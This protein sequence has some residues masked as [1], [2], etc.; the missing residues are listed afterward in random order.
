MAIG[1]LFFFPTYG[2]SS[3]RRP[4]QEWGRNQ[5]GDGRKELSSI[6]DGDNNADFFDQQQMQPSNVVAVVLR[7]AAADSQALFD[8]SE[9]KA[10]AQ[11]DSL[12]F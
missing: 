7:T 1:N 11:C 8:N 3:P 12:L 5:I 10:A 4:A 6:H 2:T 9:N